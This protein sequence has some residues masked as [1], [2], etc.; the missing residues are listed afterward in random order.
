[1]TQIKV[2]VGCGPGKQKGCIGVDIAYT[3]QV[4]IIADCLHLP[5]KEHC[6]D[7]LYA[8]SLLEHFINPYL[9][10]EEIYRVIKHPHGFCEFIVPNV[11]TYSAEQDPTHMFVTDLAHWNRI[12]SSFFEK[13]QIKP[14]GVKFQSSSRKWI[15][16]QIALIEDGLWDLAQGFTFRCSYLKPESDI[17]YLYV[18]H[19]IEKYARESGRS[20]LTPR[21]VVKLPPFH[22]DY[23]KYDKLKEVVFEK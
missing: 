17:T 2:D 13:I 11:G 23:S 15:A 21:Q 6:I 14:F 4:D 19:F 3:D 8:L 20:Y 5:F 16:Q 18:P 9:L 7:I 1:M 10:L 22:I 12:I